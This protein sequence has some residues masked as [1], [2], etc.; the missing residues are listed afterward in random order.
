MFLRKTICNFVAAS[1]VLLF[2]LPA[3]ATNSAVASGEASE[4]MAE[5][6]VHLAS[7]TANLSAATMQLGADTAISLG[8]PVAK[9]IL[10]GAEISGDT[11]LLTGNILKD[12][13]ISTAELS[14]DLAAAGV[15]LSSD[16]AAVVT[17]ATLAGIYLSTE[18]AARFLDQAIEITAASGRLS[19][20]AAELALELTAAGVEMSA[21]S[22]V[23]V[24]NAGKKG[25][26]LSEEAAQDFIDKSFAIAADCI[27][28]A[29]I[30]E[31]YVIMTAAEA[32]RLL[33]EASLQTVQSAIKGG[34]KAYNFTAETATHLHNLG[35]DS[36]KLS[37]ELSKKAANATVTAVSH[38]IKSADDAVVIVI[39]TGS[40]LIVT[41]I[42]SLTEKVE[43]TTD[44]M[45]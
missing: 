10:R 42:D 22:A 8:K 33:K 45:K 29:Q 27:E 19:G 39:N 36:I 41:A 40:G 34:Q 26:K 18:T 1:C 9:T 5:A 37:K 31:R 32:N 28:A 11:I 2:S 21:D 44:A 20:E 38:S 16:T 30:T 6:A 3:F 25:I 15:E 4:D 17:G 24:A 43:K 12:G 35:I 14:A 23:L 13:L 7:A